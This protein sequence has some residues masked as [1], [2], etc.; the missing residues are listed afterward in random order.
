M[1]SIGARLRRDDLLDDDSVAVFHSA[2]H[3]VARLEISD[4]LW[5]LQCL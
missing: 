4:G 5:R 3:A 2:S 1:S